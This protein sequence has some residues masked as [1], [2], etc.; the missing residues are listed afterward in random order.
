M[1][2]VFKCDRCGKLF[3]PPKREQK[4]KMAGNT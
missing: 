4:R 2:K 1:S 3:D